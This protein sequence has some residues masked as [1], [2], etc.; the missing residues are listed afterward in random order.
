MKIVIGSDHGGFNLKEEIK[1][2]LEEEGYDYTDVGTY[3]PE[4]C[5]YPDIAEKACAGI[6]DGTYDRGIL[7]CGTGIGIGIAANKIKGIRAALCGDCFSAEYSRLHNDANVITLGERVLGP[8]LA[9]KIVKIYLTTDFEGGRHAQRVAK[10][11]ALE[12]K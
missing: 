6:V 11:T 4:R 9:K 1:K 2:F 3:T 7:V 10:I 5:D 8:G 12:N